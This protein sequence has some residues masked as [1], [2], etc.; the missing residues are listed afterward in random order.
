MMNSIFKSNYPGGNFH[1]FFSKNDVRKV[2]FD[3]IG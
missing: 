3:P 2:I 1:A